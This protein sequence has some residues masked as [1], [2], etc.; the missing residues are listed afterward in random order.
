M[1]INFSRGS[2]SAAVWSAGS[3][4]E[5]EGTLEEEI[6]SQIESGRLVAQFLGLVIDDPRA[7]LLDLKGF[8]YTFFFKWRNKTHNNR[9][10]ERSYNL[11]GWIRG[12]VFFLLRNCWVLFL[13]PWLV[14]LLPE[15]EVLLNFYGFGCHGK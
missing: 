14:S 2:C 12:I 5:V 4:G 9:R 13:W 3:T 15:S 7:T 10:Y 11:N 1:W 8:G 6:R